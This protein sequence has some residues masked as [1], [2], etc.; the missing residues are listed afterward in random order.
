MITL[1]IDEVGRG[2]LAGPVVAG[3][4]ILDK[5]IAGLRDSKRL[6]RIKRERL[7]TEIILSAKAIGLGWAEPSE[8]DNL[9]L[10]KAVRLAML[11]AQDK[12]KIN[13]D[14]II[15]DGN[16]NFLKEDSRVQTIIKADDSIPAVSAA[17]IIA[18]VARDSYM[19][20][21][22]L[23]YPHYCFDKHVGYGTKVHLEMIKRYGV[24]ILHRRSCKPVKALEH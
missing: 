7:S 13:Y 11:R 15:I 14:K 12:I 22:A 4:V 19:R 8:V 20:K 5:P 2:C 16:Y 6:T 17:S 18:K 23:L 3:A 10:T 1:G 21:Q 24:C 9:G